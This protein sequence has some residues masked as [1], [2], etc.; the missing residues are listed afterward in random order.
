MIVK[1]FYYIQP[2]RAVINE[3]TGNSLRNM[4]MYDNKLVAYK[5]ASTQLNLEIKRLDR[6]ALVLTQDKMYHFNVLSQD[7]EIYLIRKP[8]Q[9]SDVSK[10]RLSIVL[11]AEDI[12]NLP[13]DRYNYSI[14][15]TSN[16]I[17]YLL[18]LTTDGN[19]VGEIEIKENAMPITRPPFTQHTFTRTRTIVNPNEAFDVGK[20]FISSR[21][22]VKT[23]R[24]TNVL[25][26]EF[27][28]YVGRFVIQY[29]KDFDPN[30]DLDWLDSQTVTVTDNSYEIMLG[31]PDAKYY[32]VLF[33]E[34]L[35]NEGKIL[36]LSYN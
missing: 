32:R 3:E 12:D 2:I 15:Y 1:A 18:Y 7:G 34:E 6:K 27:D 30:H 28:N 19:A 29:S 24:E 22:P 9:I 16:N 25:K 31:I 14:S 20:S 5:N 35:E 36:K 13:I 23:D 21:L 11:N 33:T 26:L 17:E 10:G 4:P 8:F